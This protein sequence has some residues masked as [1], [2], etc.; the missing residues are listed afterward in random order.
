MRPEYGT[1][2]SPKERLLDTLS[3]KPV[4]ERRH[5]LQYHRNL[6]MLIMTFFD[7][8]EYSS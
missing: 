7:Y 5:F 2:Y 8:F 6:K 3:T 4:L 1:Y